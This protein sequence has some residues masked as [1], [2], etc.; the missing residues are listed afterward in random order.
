MDAASAASKAKGAADQAIE[1]GRGRDPA[2]GQLLQ[3]VLPQQTGAVITQ[4]SHQAG[5][6]CEQNTTGT[7]AKVF[8]G[9]GLAVCLP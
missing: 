5:N 2:H 1:L 8:G 6:V 3:Q 7:G 4:R 9:A